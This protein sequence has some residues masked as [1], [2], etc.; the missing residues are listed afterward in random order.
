M[1][2]L[3]HSKYLRLLMFILLCLLWVQPAATPP[4]SAQGQTKLVLAFYYSWFSPDSFGPGRTPYQPAQ[5]YYS[6]DA[7][8]IQRHVNEARSAGIDGFVQS[9]YGPQVENNQTE[10]NFQTLLNI[11]AGSGFTAAV[12]FEVGS[13]FF[14]SNDD[15][16]NALRTLLSTHATHSA[17]LRV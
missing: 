17:Y 13:P 2:D 1:W 11:A 12:D 15:R 4:A 5:A 3:L 8:T 9:W 7:G 6:S 16:I 14:A 10:P